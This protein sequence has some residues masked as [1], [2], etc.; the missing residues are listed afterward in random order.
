MILLAIMLAGMASDPPQRVGKLT[1]PAIAEAS[2]VVASRRYP[3]IFWVHND[4]G[5][6]ATLFAV[7]RDGSLVGEFKVAATNLDWEDIAIDDRGH[8]YIG[9]IGNNTRA[10]PVRVIY[11]VDE[12]DPA[13]PTDVPLPVSFASYYRYKKGEVFDAE[14]LFIENNRAVLV[15]KNSNKRDADLYAVPLAPPGSLV[16]PVKAEKISFLPGFTEAATG[17]DLSVDGTLLAVCSIERVRVYSRDGDRGWKLESQVASPPG[18]V[19]AICWDGRDL[20]L[21]NEERSVFRIA[22]KTWREARKK[23]R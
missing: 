2:G 4:S 1:H 9:D 18:Q 21:A 22:E 13:V 15:S 14:G 19:E 6:P 11:R 8:L 20:I 10:L 7:R 16:R 5:H 17:A 12:P 3:D 23:A